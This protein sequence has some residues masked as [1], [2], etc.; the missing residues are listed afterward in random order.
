[1]GEKTYLRRL[2]ADNR[3]RVR[4]T[5]EKGN[6]THFVVQYETLIENKWVAITRY[7]TAHGFAHQDTMHPDGSHDKKRLPFLSNRQ[8]L[9]AAIS[10]IALH[11][12]TYRERYQKEVNM[13]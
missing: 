8:A 13:L 9:T 4:F 11:W 12:A 10:D 2:G 1:M 5:T 6:V 7:D 3:M